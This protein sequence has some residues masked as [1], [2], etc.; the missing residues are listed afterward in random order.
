MFDSTI[1][2]AVTDV[3][4]MFKR[5]RHPRYRVMEALGLPLP[6]GAYDEFWALRGISLELERGDS[7]GLIGQNG[8]G[9][10]TLLNIVCGRLQPSS[11]SITVRGN[12]QALMEL[13]TGF[14][15][16]FSGRENI[17]S[18]L[19]YQGVIGREARRRVDE[20]IDFSELADF[21]DQPVKTYST[22]M[23][24]RLAFS[25]AT[26][27]VPDVLIIDEVLGAGDA[28]F[29]AKCAERM[30]RLTKESGATVLF[31][32]H[33]IQAVQ[34]L[35]ERA[36]WIDHGE[37]RMAGAA[38][39][40]SKAYYADVNAREE[41]RLRAQTT[42]AVAR[43]RGR[44][45]AAGLAEEG[46]KIEQVAVADQQSSIAPQ[47]EILDRRLGLSILAY[48]QEGQYGTFAVSADA[49]ET[50]A[51]GSQEQ[52]ATERAPDG[53]ASDDACRASRARDKWETQ[54][55]RFTDISTCSVAT[56]MRQHVF[57]RG[58]PVMF[59]IDL[60]L[61]DAVPVCWLACV[62]YD[63][64]GNRV[65]LLVE[66]LRR[67][68]AAGRSEITLRIDHIN[69][70]QGEY[71]VSF[72]LLPVFDYNWAEPYRLPYLCHWDRCIFFK[73]DE[74]YHGVISL[75]LV[76]LSATVTIGSPAVPVS[77]ALARD[78]AE[79]TG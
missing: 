5:Y 25:T 32:S 34:R 77:E 72:D 71:V 65:S 44:D 12:V 27:I 6:K 57:G 8:A 49:A 26:A 58:E 1:A 21:I 40:V 61:A 64:L 15:P 35:C 10:S 39:E 14:H 31:V 69:L 68:L 17:L 19:A 79:A 62:I 18:S 24:A 45:E 36:I 33:D 78:A 70:R 20:I 50:Y 46:A 51:Q 29:A 47:G 60:E 4:R 75:G 52:A 67:G 38:F 48:A 55:G 22:G 66:E 7:L 42:S 63:D 2:I 3:S 23:Y 41:A 28:Y 74:S 11:G 73:I 56:G 13:G 76:A 37:I 53:F 30:H 54:E 43:M 9:K 59:R 16:E